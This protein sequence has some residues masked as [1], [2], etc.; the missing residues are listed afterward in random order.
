MD[1]AIRN[2]TLGPDGYGLCSCAWC[3]RT[4]SLG[5]RIEVYKDLTSAPDYICPDCYEET[6]TLPD[7]EEATSYSPRD[8]SSPHSEDTDFA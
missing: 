7:D 6:R 4:L 2:T 1:N 3:S 5:H 8:C